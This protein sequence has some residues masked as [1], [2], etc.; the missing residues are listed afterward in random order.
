MTFASSSL[1][2]GSLVIWFGGLLSLTLLLMAQNTIGVAFMLLAWSVQSALM[3]A[4][5]IDSARWSTPAPVVDT[6]SYEPDDEVVEDLDDVLE[7]SFPASDPPSWT[8]G[9]A[10][11]RSTRR[12]SRTWPPAVSASAGAR[13]L[14]AAALAVQ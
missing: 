13:P 1:I 6:A 11:V 2:T 12:T 5:L 14:E 4:M 10:R 9:I 3:V 8:S 7:Q